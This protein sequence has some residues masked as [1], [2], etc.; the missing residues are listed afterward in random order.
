MCPISNR[1]LDRMTD[2]GSLLSNL[3]LST[4]RETIYNCVLFPFLS[5]CSLDMI[6]YWTWEWERERGRLSFSF[7]YHSLFV[8]FL[9]VCRKVNFSHACVVW[10]QKSYFNNTFSFL[11]LLLLLLFPYNYSWLRFN[12]TSTCSLSI[13]R[14]MSPPVCEYARLFFFSQ[15]IRFI[16]NGWSRIEKWTKPIKKTN[17]FHF[18]LL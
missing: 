4:T 17:W 13:S 5:F 15:R 10:Q 12:L 8:S 1:V 14:L 6:G 9:P 18:L 2:W 16:H 11:F 3:C 7:V